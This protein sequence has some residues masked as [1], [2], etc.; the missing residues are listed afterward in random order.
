DAATFSGAAPG[1]RSESVSSHSIR[2]YP[3]PCLPR[4]SA[5]SKCSN[6][7]RASASPKP[8]PRSRASASSG[9]KLRFVGER[10]LRL[11]GLLALPLELVQRDLVQ[12][13]LVAAAALTPALE[14]PAHEREHQATTGSCFTMPTPCS[15]RV[16]AIRS[17]ISTIARAAGAV[18]SATTSGWPASPCSRSRVS[19]GA[20]PR[21]GTCRS[22]AGAAQPP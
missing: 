1:R 5:S 14:E 22:A 3:W 8:R 4:R 19:S 6:S 21:T 11:L 10:E 2:E 20:V 15:R 9:F 13:R 12:Q 7:V 16:A 18:G 17:A